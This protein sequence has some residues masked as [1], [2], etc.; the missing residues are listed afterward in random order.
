MDRSSEGLKKLNRFLDM[1]AVAQSNTSTREALGEREVHCEDHGPYTSSGVRY[2]GRREIWTRCPDCDAAEESARLKAE[3]DAKAKRE[4]ERLE[5]LIQQAAI[6]ARFIGRSFDNFKASTP[7]Q[8]NAL[9]V[10]RAFAGEFDANYR[11]GRGLILSGMPG[12]GKSHLAGAVLQAIL[13]EYCGLY[14][15]CLGLIRMVRTT[16]RKDS[17]RSETETLQLLADVPLL[18]IDEIGVQYGTDGEQTILFEVLDARYRA[19][20]PTILLTNQ[21]AAGLKAFLGERTYDRLTETCK[22]I[23]FDWESYRP[24]ARKEAA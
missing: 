10:V 20:L 1:S 8:R 14:L 13:P 24:T 19:M 7:G 6:P 9:A 17:E 23:A 18:V 4:Q 5:R 22:W 3:A 2:L 15:T 12:T 16:W 21:D 11:N